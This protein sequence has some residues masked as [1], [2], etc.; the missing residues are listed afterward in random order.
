MIPSGLGIYGSAQN[1]RNFPTLTINQAW[2]IDTFLA[3]YEAKIVTNTAL[4]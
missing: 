4:G 2:E 1:I 3:T